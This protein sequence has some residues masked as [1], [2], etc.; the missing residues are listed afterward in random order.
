MEELFLYVGDT[1][2]KRAWETKTHTH[3][4]EEQ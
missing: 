4:K 1:N 3:I 2:V